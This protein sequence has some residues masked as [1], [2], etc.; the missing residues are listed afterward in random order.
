VFDGGHDWDA[1]SERID[2]SL[3]FFE[4]VLRAEA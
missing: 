4:A 3:L 1:W 2:H